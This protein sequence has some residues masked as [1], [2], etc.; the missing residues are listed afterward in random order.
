MAPAGFSEDLWN[1]GLRRIRLQNQSMRISILPEVAG[2][3][4]EMTD[5]R[6][7]RNWLWS[8]SAL[9]HGRP[10]YGD[11]FAAELDS[12]GWDDILLSVTPGQ[13]E[14]PDG[15]RCDV[16]DH[17]DLVGQSWDVDQLGVDD[18]GNPACALTASGKAL[19]YAWR[20]TVV[21]ES[22]RPVL[23]LDYRLENTGSTPLPWFWCAHP[24]I[25]MEPGM[26]IHIPEGQEI[27]VASVHGMSSA[28]SNG[29]IRWPWLPTAS[30]RPIN[31]S[32]C[33][34]EPQGGEKFAAK[35]F[36]R[37]TLPG[38]V[39]VGSADGSEQL[40]M[41]FDS[42]LVPWLGLWL[43]NRGWSGSTGSPY[44]NLGLEPSTVS[45]DSL[46]QALAMDEVAFL[47]PGERREWSVEVSL[48]PTQA[49]ATS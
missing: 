4:I 47:R 8:N 18:R 30:G 48:D 15:T 24:L 9:P 26:L 10:S 22:D 38:Q 29:P 45:C 35:V 2:K 3:I 32:A 14:L 20:R 44:L 7:G 49:A 33:F 13:I 16:P 39:S 12:G 36:V 43:N 28:N 17:G 42:T 23:R 40:T 46:A 1:G 37:S 31:L 25:A 21:L 19:A 11:N 6:S 34:G 5:L 27:L 41:R